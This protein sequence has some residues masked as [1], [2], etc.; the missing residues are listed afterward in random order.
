VKRRDRK[1]FHIYFKGNIFHLEFAL[2]GQSHEIGEAGRWFHWIDGKF[3]KYFRINP[4]LRPQKV[5]KQRKEKKEF[6]RDIWFQ[7]GW[8]QN[9]AIQNFAKFRKKNYLREN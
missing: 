4:R 5:L 6:R 9:F 1:T 8:I 7:L 2:M 3:R